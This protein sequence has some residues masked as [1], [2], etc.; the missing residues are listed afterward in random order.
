MSLEGINCVSEGKPSNYII[1][2]I[3][4]AA[5][6]QPGHSASQGTKENALHASSRPAPGTTISEKEKPLLDGALSHLDK[7][8]RNYSHNAA[9]HFESPRIQTAIYRQ[10][11]Q[12][13]LN[14]LMGERVL[15]VPNADK[16]K[17]TK[18]AL[19]ENKVC[20]LRGGKDSDTKYYYYVSWYKE[21]CLA[22]EGAEVVYFLSDPNTSTLNAATSA[23]YLRD[24]IF[25]DSHH[26]NRLSCKG[27]PLDVMDS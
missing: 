1:K 5:R 8:S 16:L 23:E 27:N 10:S 14:N 18:D 7:Q 25:N 20:S 12:I 19:K 11:R 6:K 13:S 2:Y 15:I 4:E 26:G 22:S 21:Y 3:K 17:S 24:P 9:S